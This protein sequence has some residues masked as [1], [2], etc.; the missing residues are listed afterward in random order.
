[1]TIDEIKSI[2]SDLEIKLQNAVSTMQLN[3][4]IKFIRAQLAQI[5]S[6]CPHKEGQFDYHTPSNKRCPICGKKWEE[7]E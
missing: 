3:D 2:R 7:K 1:M 4:T 5:Q 6:E